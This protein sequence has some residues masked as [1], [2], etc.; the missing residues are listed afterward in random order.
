[1]ARGRC[2]KVIIPNELDAK[3]ILA[4]L[5]WKDKGQSRAY[6]CKICWGHIWHVTSQDPD[7]DRN[8]KKTGS[9]DPQSIDAESSLAI[10]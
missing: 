6:E 7:P 2:G 9:N 5:V 3:I 1:M 10:G 4:R 8:E